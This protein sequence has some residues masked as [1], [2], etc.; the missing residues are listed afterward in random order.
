MEFY[1]WLVPIIALYYIYRIV[2]QFRN[3][4]R[5]VSST[6]VWIVF[7]V[8]CSVLAI[9]PD[10][11]SDQIAK[12]LGFKSNVNAVI[13][14]AL[15]LLFVFMFY[16]TAIIEKMERQLSDT[17]RELAL[18]NQ[19]LKQQLLDSKKISDEDSLRS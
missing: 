19:K 14:V 9:I 8:T 7:W 12:L 5:L 10:L 18:E 4:K 2:G 6:L 3:Q 13:F 17:I 16:L 1:Q 11:V 15:G